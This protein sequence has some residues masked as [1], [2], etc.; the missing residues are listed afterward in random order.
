VRPSLRPDLCRGLRAPPK[1]VLMFGPPGTGKTMIAKAVAAQSG[2]TF[3]AMSASTLMSKWVG[4]GEKVR[5]CPPFP[6]PPK[7]PSHALCWF[8]VFFGDVAVC[9]P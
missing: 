6:I 4:E 9:G 2:A 1:G 8:C 3:F 5:T 7:P